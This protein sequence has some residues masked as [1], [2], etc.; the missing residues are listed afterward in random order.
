VPGGGEEGDEEDARD[1]LVENVEGD[2][3]VGE[4]VAAIPI[5]CEAE[6][7]IEG[8]VAGTNQESAGGQY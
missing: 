2:V 5:T 6:A 4:I 7:G 3:S 8:N 1:E